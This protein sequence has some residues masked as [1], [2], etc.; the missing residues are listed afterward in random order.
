[1]LHTIKQAVPFDKRRFE[2]VCLSDADGT[3]AVHVL[4]EDLTAVQYVLKDPANRFA[5]CSCP[6][7]TQHRPCK[8]QV[9]WLLSLAPAERETVA[10][11]LVLSRLG[12]RLG[13]T[14]CC[15]MESIYDL[16]VALK[17]LLP[18]QCHWTFQCLSKQQ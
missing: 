17:N 6:V 10:E 7:A 9:A 13:F 4:S 11:R 16:S 3:E 14:G 12:M 15:S 5:A 1:M 18:V 2:L 8:H